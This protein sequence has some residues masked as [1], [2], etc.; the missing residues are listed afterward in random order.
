M[1]AKAS[2]LDKLLA[3]I[4]ARRLLDD[5][6]QQFINAGKLAYD[7]LIEKIDSPQL[8]DYQVI[9][10]LQIIVTLRYI[11]EPSHVIAKILN[12]TQDQRIRVRSAASKIAIALLLQAEHCGTPAYQLN[13][14][15]LVNLLERSLMLDLDTS[16]TSY[17]SEF[18]NGQN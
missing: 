14:K 12:L 5:D 1:T 6:K 11:G 2:S 18:I 3:R 15:E 13:R 9:N 17:V 7:Y 4:N 10:A 8:T 16:S